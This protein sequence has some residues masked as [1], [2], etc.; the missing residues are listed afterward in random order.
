MKLKHNK[1]RNTAFLYETLIK[2]LTKAVVK[3]DI[4]R[5]NIIVSM[6][7]EH[8]SAGTT[9]GTELALYKTLKDTSHLDVYTAERLIAE[10][11]DQYASLDKKEVFA[12]Q[13]VLIESINI[14][15]G[16]NTFSNFVPNYKTLASISQIFSDSLPAKEKVLLERN[17]IGRLVSKPKSK[18]HGKEMKH[19]DNLVLKTVIENFNKKYDGQLLNEQ[20]DLLNNYILS[21][22][23]SGLEFKVYLNEELTRIKDSLASLHADEAIELD[24]EMTEKLA[25]VEETVGRFQT[26][27]IDTKMIEKIMAIQ[28]LIA[29][30]NI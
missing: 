10:T 27:K 2:E 29:E 20:R 11:K 23:N 1:K 19:I 15:V 24:K 4:E 18:E 21:F 16:G 3:K 30:C 22:D 9:L 8:F 26:K 25:R 28:G 17:L 7:R 13:S 12:K 6:L 14:R 5:K